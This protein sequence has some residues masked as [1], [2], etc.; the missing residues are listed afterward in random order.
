M[1]LKITAKISFGYAF[2]VGLLGCHAM[3]Q[4][5]VWHG[6]DVGGEF[7]QNIVRFT[8]RIQV[9][10]RPKAGKLHNAAR[11]RPGAGGF[12]IIKIE[13]LGHIAIL[14]CPP[15]PQRPPLSKHERYGRLLT[16]TAA[17]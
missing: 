1:F 2:L 9:F 15:A 5:R 4:N 14:A 17:Y 13:G 10:V 12:G 7:N 11:T 8:N 6:Q 3:Y 16:D